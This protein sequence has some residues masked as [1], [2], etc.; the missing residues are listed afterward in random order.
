ML[1]G[2]RMPRPFVERLEARFDVFGPLPPPFSTSVA[3]LPDA[4]AQ[5]AGVPVAAA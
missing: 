2:A 5:A 3:A 4:D 1:L